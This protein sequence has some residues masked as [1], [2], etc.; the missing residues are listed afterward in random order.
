LS[1]IE[2]ILNQEVPEQVTV[3]TKSNMM[4]G[5]TDAGIKA[6]PIY[7]APGPPDG[8]K[9]TSLRAKCTPQCLLEEIPP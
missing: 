7:T 1:I 9:S 5:S 6:R 2:R 3:L 4:L 8:L